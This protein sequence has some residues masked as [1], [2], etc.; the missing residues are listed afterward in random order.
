MKGV[1]DDRSSHNVANKVPVIL[2]FRV[3][4]SSKVSTIFISFWA[5]LCFFLNSGKNSISVGTHFREFVDGCWSPRVSELF[6]G[7]FIHLF[8]LFFKLATDLWNDTGSKSEHLDLDVTDGHIWIYE[9][10]QIQQISSQNHTQNSDTQDFD[11]FH[12]FKLGVDI[13]TSLLDVA[14]YHVFLFFWDQWYKIKESIRDT[15]KL[16]QDIGQRSHI[17]R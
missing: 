9:L 2:V 10:C 1:W 16:V 6:D 4:T 12:A 7:T 3:Y 15:S 17:K 8:P 14:L 11:W 5:N 13:V